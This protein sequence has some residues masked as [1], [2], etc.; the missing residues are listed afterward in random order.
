[1]PSA[2][3]QPPARTPEQ[4]AIL[5]RLGQ[6]VA[7]LR[8]NRTYVDKH[9]ETRPLSQEELGKLPEVDLHRTVISEIERGLV[10]VSILTAARIAAGLDVTVA[11]LVHDIDA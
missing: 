3:R 7:D 6:N 1:M 5:Q 9:G 4:V 11:E 8:Q 10:N 2:D